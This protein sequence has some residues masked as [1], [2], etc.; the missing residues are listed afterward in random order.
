[1]AALWNIPV[2]FVCENNHYGKLRCLVM[3]AKHVA[4]PDTTDTRG[5]MI[6][7]YICSLR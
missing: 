4:S 3:L 1:M 2:I 5:S 6:L 7:S